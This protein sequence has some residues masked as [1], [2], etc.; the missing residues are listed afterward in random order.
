MSGTCLALILGLAL[1][2]DGDAFR[3]WV[4]QEAAHENLNV[5]NG[6]NFAMPDKTLSPYVLLSPYLMLRS[7][8]GPTGVMEHRGVRWAYGPY[9]DGT[10]PLQAAFGV[11]IPDKTVLRHHLL[12]DFREGVP[13]VRAERFLTRSNIWIELDY[14]RLTR[15]FPDG[16]PVSILPV[17]PE[18]DDTTKLLLHA[19]PVDGDVVAHGSKL[20]L[21]STAPARWQVNWTATTFDTSNQK[22]LP[23]DVPNID[24]LGDPLAITLINQTPSET[25]T[26]L[27]VRFSPPGRWRSAAPWFRRLEGD[28]ILPPHP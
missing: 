19:G 25:R 12:F 13:V 6:G 4:Y 26:F 8:L 18:G 21:R 28:R 5:D 27:I 9:P 22:W 24:P 23:I 10:E 1:T 20:W 7:P 14:V 11:A 17:L 15:T 3:K 16:R 2:A